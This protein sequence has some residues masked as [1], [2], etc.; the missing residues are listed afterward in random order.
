MIEAQLDV[1]R[2]PVAT[3]LVQNGTL[4]TGDIFV[5]G[6]QWGKVRALI[7]DQGR[8]G[9]RGGPSVPVEVLGLNGTPEAGD[10]L[11]VVDTEAQAREI[12]EYRE[13]AGQGQTRRRWCRDHAGTADGQGQ[14][15]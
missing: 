10:V 9:E 7:D 6:E 15:G 4:R 3:V 12:A 11:N 1:G 5:V 14:G 8:P 13:A 2:G